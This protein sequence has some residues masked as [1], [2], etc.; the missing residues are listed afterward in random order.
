MKLIYVLVFGSLVLSASANA[1]RSYVCSN[2]GQTREIH[3]VYD[4][5]GKEVPCSVL[6]KKADDE[7]VLW[8]AQQQL[9]YCES[10]AAE[11]AEK[12]ESWGWSCVEMEAA[13]EQAASEEAASEE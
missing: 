7:R 5:P 2:A 10:K 6:Y 3:I 11:F 1:N 4:E 13:E 12:Q 8:S 9:G